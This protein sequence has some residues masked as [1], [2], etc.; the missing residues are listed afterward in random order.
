MTT[1][2]TGGGTSNLDALAVTG[3]ADF[4]T[5]TYSGVAMGRMVLGTSQNTTSGTSIDFTSIPSWVKKITLMFNGVSTAGAGTNIVQV[6]LG[7]SGGVEVTGYSGRSA[8]VNSGAGG[9]NPMS[10]GFSLYGSGGAANTNNGAITIYLMGSNTWACSGNVSGSSSSVTCFI[11][12][13]KALSGVL[14]R[15]RLTT[16][17]GTDTF[18]AGSV[19]ILYE[20]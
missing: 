7:T 12:G 14:D 8:Y 1:S 17:S 4:G 2:L 6:Q 18:D 10:A 19:N 15:L 3:A 13:V 20:G 9:D 11:S 16:A 5:P